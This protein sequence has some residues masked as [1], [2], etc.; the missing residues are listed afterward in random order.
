MGKVMRKT[1]IAVAVLIAVGVATY[2]MLSNPVGRLVKLA[3]NGFGPKLTQAEVHV[4]S[5]KIATRD[6]TGT[7][8]GLFLGNPK[9]FKTDYALKAGTIG[10]DLDTRSIAKKV[11]V[12]HKILI[13]AP[14]IIYEKGKHGSNF[15]AIQ[16][17]VTQ[18]LGSGKGKDSSQSGND[19]GKKL[20]I[21]SFVIHDAKVNY[22]GVADLKL[23]DIELH[24]IGK[25]SGGAT[26]AQVVKT[27]IAALNAKI[28][29]ALAKTV[30]IGAVGGP[31]IGA[32]MA[33][34]GMLGK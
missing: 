15:D 22:N 7:L 18:Y 30:A 17:N 29:L 27:I 21:D 6:G 31:V 34:K 14:S 26:S 2:F 28:V 4:S 11:V 25:R 16:R 20:I 33:I 32:G 24:D 5:V 19:A 10:I 13:D 12:I 9:G 8:S 1:L 3:V 23:P